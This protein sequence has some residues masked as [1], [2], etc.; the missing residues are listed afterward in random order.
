M[1]AADLS[2]KQLREQHGKDEAS[3]IRDC[4]SQSAITGKVRQKTSARALELIETLRRKGKPGLMEIFFE[5][6]GLSTQEGLALMCLA[7][8]LLRV[9]DPDT[10]GSLIADKVVPA[11]WSEHLGHSNSTLVNA[12]TWGLLL[13]GR[14]LNDEQDAGTLGL[15]RGAVR[16][17]GEPVIRG[18]VKRAMAELGAQFVLGQTIEEAMRRGG[19]AEQNGYTFSYDMLGE[20]ALT[21]V[22]AD[23]Y[24]EKYQEAIQAI[25][26]RCVDERPQANPGISIKLSALHP[27]YEV[28]QQD[29][30]VRELTPR[31]RR[32]ALL[33]RSSNMGFT[34]DAEEA[35]R[36]DLSLDIIERVFSDPGLTGWAGFGVVVQAYGKRANALIEW[37]Y[38][39][40]RRHG[41]GMMIRLVKGAYWDAEIKQAQ[42]DGV[43]N[44]PVFTAKAA[45]DASYICCAKSLLEKAEWLY[46]Q[47]A[48][49]NAHTMAAI[50]ELTTDRKR[51]EFQRLH[52]MGGALHELVKN[53]EQ[54][55]CRI[56]APVGMHRD[57]LAY[58]VRRLLENGANSSF[59]NQMA[60]PDIPASQIAADPFKEVQQAFVP[61]TGPIKKPAALFLPERIN[62][63]GWN[64]R[65]RDDLSR[66][67][68][69]RGSFQTAQWQAAP[70][71]A[72]GPNGNSTVDII[73]PA[74]AADK[75]GAV[76]ATS[77]A[78]LSAA[79]RRARTWTDPGLPARA[80]TLKR[81]ADIYEANSGE[82]LAVLSREAGKTLADALA[83]LREAVDFLRYYAAQALRMGAAQPRGLF[84]CISPWNF[85]LAI[86]TGQ[87]AA[88]LVTG[89]GVLAKPA[90]T[91]P[92]TAMLA[93]RCL[94]E[95][96]V[97]TEV[98]QLLPGTGREV[99]ALLTAATEISGVCF[100]GSTQTAR[101]IHRMMAD[102]LAPGAPLIAE[103]GGINAMIVDSTALPEQAVRDSI[104]SAF[105][106]AGQRCSSLRMLYLQEDIA[107]PFLEMLTGAMKE[108]SLGDP[109]RL[110]TDIGPLISGEARLGI[111]RYVAARRAEHRVLYTA[112]TPNRGHFFSPTII[113]VD[114]IGDLEREIFGPVLHVAR[115]RPQDIEN[116][117]RDIN[118]SGYGLT[119]GLHSRIDG[120]V[121]YLQ[122]R[123]KAGNLYVNRNQ[124]GAV[125]GS[126][127][128]GGEGLSGTGPKAG[129]PR[130]LQRFIATP[131][132]RPAR[133]KG[134]AIT[135]KQGV[136]A[137]IDKTPKAPEIP[138]ET[139]TMPGPTG[140]TNQ[141]S[142]YPRGLV[143]CLGPALEQVR[144]QAEIARSHGC[145][146]V[147]IA[148]DARGPDSLAGALPASVLG[149]LEGLD[150]V[151][152]WADDELAVA[153]RQALAAREGPIIPLVT[154]RDLAAYCT[155]ERHLCIN[156]TAAG[157]NAALLAGLG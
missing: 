14:V 49:H 71:P 150:I 109:W 139:I 64:L 149:G 83:E 22:D 110:S 60:D 80:E 90:E 38:A 145:E 102:K 148:A 69:L 29:R 34:I 25:A 127:P 84:T 89:N 77:P 10:V 23:A 21:M 119:F 2:R 108:L 3:L 92:L 72:L 142:S 52:G 59:V 41:R 74:D 62:S 101:S 79:L 143:L 46:P 81:A 144:E 70:D 136:Q 107:E 94:H 26:K 122:K 118:A 114:G 154:G 125:P 1:A 106:S 6:Y 58:L 111:E 153:Y 115:W 66:L 43:E 44:F 137:L 129:G 75:V 100:T 151:A 30:V 87:I 116:V 4:I 27:R 155:L 53:R 147:L 130:Y 86:F 133:G 140:E 96:G 61:D 39:L 82:F 67:D 33:A 138:L 131:Q 63:R 11:T 120:R 99:G 28:L 95:A 113:K 68:E 134:P 141:C 13:T 57:L 47:F 112:Q 35:D 152:Y 16:R 5:E 104:A 54:T 103:T 55:R 124:I 117:I 48:T 98:L 121:R 88:A 37:L 24:L 76:T 51:F 93:V 123:I 128:F 73:N 8:A 7:E 17:L 32:L 12:S 156:T 50:L 126:Q 42:V 85:P 65:N 20:A 18:A 45:T 135:H 157:G 78:Q 91:T 105:Q 40:A 146:A 36:L 132:D 56:Y 97:P 19:R 9:P 15:L 31:V